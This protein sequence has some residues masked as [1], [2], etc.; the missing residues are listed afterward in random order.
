MLIK[1]IKVPG[2]TE[3]EFFTFKSAREDVETE[4]S[5]TFKEIKDRV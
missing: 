5:K 1:Y 2:D 4:L 3:Y